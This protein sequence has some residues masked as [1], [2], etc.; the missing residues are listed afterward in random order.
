MLRSNTPADGAGDAD[1]DV[2]VVGYPGRDFVAEIRAATRTLRK[3]DSSALLTHD[4]KG[5]GGGGA[6]EKTKRKRLTF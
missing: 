3:I 2:L 5:G 6:R 1:D 4:A